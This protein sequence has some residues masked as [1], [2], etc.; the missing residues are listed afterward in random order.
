[1]LRNSSCNHCGKSRR[2]RLPDARPPAHHRGYDKR[3]RR[4]RDAVLAREPLCR[5]CAERG[6]VVAAVL[7]DHIIPLP[8]GTHRVDNLQP[9]CTRCH[10]VKTAAERSAKA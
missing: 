7:V 2:Q 10:A 8:E 3:W 9:L 5:H 4:I 6:R 1:M